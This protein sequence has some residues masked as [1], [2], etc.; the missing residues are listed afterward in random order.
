MLYN[1]KIGSVAL[2]VLVISILATLMGK[3]N[4][5]DTN[6]LEGSGHNVHVFRLLHCRFFYISL[7]NIVLMFC[8][9]Q[10]DSAFVFIIN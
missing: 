3:W 10:W 1:Q 8:T 2:V 6:G 9:C 4:Y 5:I 7:E